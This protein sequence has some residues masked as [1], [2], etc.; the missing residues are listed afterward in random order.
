[1]SLK[2]MLIHSVHPSQEHQILIYVGMVNDIPYD[3]YEWFN[4]TKG[5]GYSI[6]AREMMNVQT[7]PEQ[8][9]RARA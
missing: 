6:A 5:T 9:R 4:C 2:C 1:M 7:L 3:A 8:G